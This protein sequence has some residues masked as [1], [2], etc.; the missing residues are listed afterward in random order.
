MVTSSDNSAPTPA[1]PA[2]SDLQE[3][4]R[5]HICGAPN[6]V[7]GFGPPLTQRGRDL[8][9]CNLAHRDRINRMLTLTAS[10]PDTPAQRQML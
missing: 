8:W 9:A 2:L 5:C 3:T 4:H 7:F 10:K 1:A 6:A